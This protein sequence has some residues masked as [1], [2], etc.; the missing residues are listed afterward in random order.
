MRFIYISIGVTAVALGIIGIALPLL[1]T[2]PFLLLAAW[3]FAKSSP[4][5]EH[6]LVNHPRLGP[7]IEAWRL[8]GAIPTRIKVIALATMSL[9]L[10]YILALSSLP[11]IAKIGSGL[12][13]AACATFI[14]TRPAA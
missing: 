4:R 13:L 8:R 1:P 12:I 10:L 2:T 11:V 9:S 5:L 7:P 3:A 14:S 6:W